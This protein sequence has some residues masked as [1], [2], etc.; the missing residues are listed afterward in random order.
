MA[1]ADQALASARLLLE[2]GDPDGACNRGYYA[3]F[4]AARAALIAAGAEIGKTHKGV[5]NAFSDQL[6]KNGPIP[7]EMGRL[8]KQAETRRY[9]ADYEG[10]PVES[11]DAR[12]MIEQAGSFVTAIHAYLG[13]R[14]P[15]DG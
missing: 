1:K 11:E 7:R 6:I 3:M 10:E 2:A 14:I 15:A 13:H 4:D 5:L 9:V 12:Q 8:L